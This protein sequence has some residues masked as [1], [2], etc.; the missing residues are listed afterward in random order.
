MIKIK[1][2]TINDEIKIY[3]LICLLEEENLEKKYFK[4][5]Y[6]KNLHDENIIY[7]KCIDEKNIIGFISCHIQNLLHHNYKVAEI[8]ELF[9]VPSFRNQG[10]GKYLIAYLSDILKNKEVKLLEVTAQKKRKKAHKFYKSNKFEQ[11]HLKFNK[12]L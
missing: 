12:F 11:T 4:D 10:V 7:L 1:K 6:L 8:Q 9:V 5:V 3:N 2:C